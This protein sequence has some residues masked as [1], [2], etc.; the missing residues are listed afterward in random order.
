MIF[1]EKSIKVE[2]LG[3]SNIV[4][5]ILITALPCAKYCARFACDK[6]T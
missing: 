2:A 3:F 1:A 6:E 4:Q 5:L